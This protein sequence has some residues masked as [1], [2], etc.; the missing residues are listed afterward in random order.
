MTMIIEPDRDERFHG[1]T[2]SPQRLHQLHVWVEEADL[3][4]KLRAAF[5]AARQSGRDLDVTFSGKPV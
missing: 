3:E 4:S 5:E 1:L 2:P